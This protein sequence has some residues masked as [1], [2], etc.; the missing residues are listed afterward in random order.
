MLE[1]QA[2]DEDEE[3]SSDEEM[4][5]SESEEE[6][7]VEEEGGDGMASTLPP[8]S[9]PH[10]TAPVDLRK[11]GTETPMSAAAPPPKQLYQVLE[12]KAAPAS[13]SAVFASEIA[14]AVPTAAPVPEGAESVLSKMTAASSVNKEGGKRRKKSGKG[15][16]EDEEDEELGKTFKF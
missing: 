5:E 6:E 4:E 11:T 8:P 12:Q 3:S 14:Y 10:A 1:P 15:E 16:D 2:P 13:A 9:I 7:E